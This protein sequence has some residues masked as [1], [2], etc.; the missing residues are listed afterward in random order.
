MRV[1]KYVREDGKVPF[2]EWFKKLDGSVKARVRARIKRVELSGNFGVVK[3]IGPIF[4]L[5]FTIAGGLRIYFG[6]D[7]EDLILLLSGGNK[8]GQQEDIKKAKEF[9]EDYNA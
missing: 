3:K 5:K 6:K 2:D 9:W 8:S 1:M 7:G 4:E